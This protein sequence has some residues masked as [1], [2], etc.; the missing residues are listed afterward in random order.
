MDLSEDLRYDKNQLICSIHDVTLVREEGISYHSPG[1]CFK[2]PP[3][4]RIPSLS[5]NRANRKRRVL[6][7]WGFAKV[8]ISQKIF[9]DIF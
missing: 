3:N 8:A 2:R 1:E 7:V 6:Q 5:K 4:R 9:L